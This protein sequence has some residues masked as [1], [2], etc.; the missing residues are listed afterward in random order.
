[1]SQ[2]TMMAEIVAAFN[3]IT[4][5]PG[6]AGI[7]AR[8][9]APTETGISAVRGNTAKVDSTHCF[10]R[11]GTAARRGAANQNSLSS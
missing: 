4:K 8:A 9:S 7:R 6:K 1:M 10:Q 3:A 11:L 5:K 2:Y